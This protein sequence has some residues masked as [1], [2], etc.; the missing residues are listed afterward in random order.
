MKLKCL[1]RF[2]HKFAQLKLIV[3]LFN[4]EFSGFELELRNNNTH[5]IS[6][7]AGGADTINFPSRSSP[8]QFEKAAVYYSP[9]YLSAAFTRCDEIHHSSPS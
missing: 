6:F 1:S 9:L 2:A 3:P 8:H 7:L 5:A 4:N